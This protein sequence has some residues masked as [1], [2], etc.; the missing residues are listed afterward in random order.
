MKKYQNPHPLW[1]NMYFKQSR[2]PTLDLQL[3]RME[4]AVLQHEWRRLSLV[5]QED[6]ASYTAQTHTYALWTHRGGGAL[7]VWAC[8][9]GHVTVTL[10][11]TPASKTAGK[12]RQK[13]SVVC[14]CS[15][16]SLS[17]V[18][19]QIQTHKGRP[20]PLT[21][22]LRHNNAGAGQQINTSELYIQYA[23]L[24]N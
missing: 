14:V 2:N 16:L 12:W 23:R 22:Q 15:V 11:Y 10:E 18:R 17:F 6:E 4:S 1:I 19:V 13:G 3:P 9:K 21:W 7:T 8:P 24:L 5:S 20:Q